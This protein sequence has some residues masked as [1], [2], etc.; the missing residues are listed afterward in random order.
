VS[1]SIQPDPPEVTEPRR[2]R[3]NRTGEIVHRADCPRTGQGSLPWNYADD[4]T[5]QA[6]AYEISRVPWLTACKVCRPDV[7]ASPTH[8]GD[9]E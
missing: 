3:R 7:S 2:Y 9:D 8:K 6:I 4:Y 1:H 5:P